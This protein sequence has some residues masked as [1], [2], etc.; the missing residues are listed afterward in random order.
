MRSY[1]RNAVGDGLLQ[2]AQVRQLGQKALLAVF[3]VEPELIDVRSQSATPVEARSRDR[4]RMPRGL[5]W[6]FPVEKSNAYVDREITF[7]PDSSSWEIA[8]SF[9]PPRN[10][11]PG[12]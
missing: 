6:D 3:E 5:K 8:G 10:T 7:L 11:A 12:P 9:A 4:H 2:E 1:P